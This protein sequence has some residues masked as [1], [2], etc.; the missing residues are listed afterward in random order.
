MRLSRDFS[1]TSIPS[2]LTPENKVCEENGCSCGILD[3]VIQL[4]ICGIARP[5]KQPSGIPVL[6][7]WQST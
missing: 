5:K 1:K 4:C 7:K 2:T 6:T 3:I